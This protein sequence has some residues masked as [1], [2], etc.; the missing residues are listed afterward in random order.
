MHQR[1]VRAAAGLVAVDHE[2][3]RPGQGGDGTAADALDHRLV[4]RAVVDEVGDGA[5]LQAMLARER[6]Q[7]RQPRHAAVVVHDLA[8]HRGRIQ[9]RQASQIAA[10]L[11][12][13]GAH[14]HAA[15]VRDQREH[16][17]GLHHVLGTCIGAAGH[18]DGVRAVCRRD[19]GGHALGRLDGHREVGP[20]RGTVA[21]RHRRQVQTPRMLGGDRHADQPA[22]VLGQEIDFLGT[23]EVGREHQVAL[24]FAILVVDQHHHVAA[25]DLLDDLVG[26]RDVRRLHGGL[27]YCAQHDDVPCSLMRRL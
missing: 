9:A 26:R 11:G 16:V 10:G 2:L 18:A 21:G 1:Q 4:R 6:H 25:A 20:V 24:V 27:G 23:D 12:V 22:P 3:H 8:Q 14:Q 13:S 15:V 19:P 7:V 5:E 17:T